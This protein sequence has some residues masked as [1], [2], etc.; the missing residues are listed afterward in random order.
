[1]AAVCG[2]VGECNIVQSSPY[3]RI[4]NIPVAVLG[5]LYYLAVLGIWFL[6]RLF[7]TQT[8]KWTP[9][10]LL[11]LSLIGVIFSIYLTALEL[12]VIYAICAWCISS[13]VISTVLMLIT[14]VAL[15]KPEGAGQTPDMLSQSA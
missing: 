6:L 8:L 3:A 2:P 1:M 5:A 14:V 10:L 7:R 15:T 9:I 12:F 4:L 11:I 13:A